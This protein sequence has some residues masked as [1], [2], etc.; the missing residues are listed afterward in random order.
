MHH[1]VGPL[2]VH[3]TTDNKAAPGFA[4]VPIGIVLIFVHL[5][6]IPLDNTPIKPARSIGPAL[7]QGGWA[8]KLLWIFIAAPTLGAALAAIIYDLMKD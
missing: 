1:R 4:G 2:T 5:I 6:S 3:F 7:F 8:P